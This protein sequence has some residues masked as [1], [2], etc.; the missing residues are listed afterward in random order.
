MNTDLN[1]GADTSQRIKGYIS[2]F[3]TVFKRDVHAVARNEDPN[4]AATRG[5]LPPPTHP[6]FNSSDG[7]RP[8]T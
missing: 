3:W 8:D 1:D 4:D 6:F 7:L 5:D 2:C